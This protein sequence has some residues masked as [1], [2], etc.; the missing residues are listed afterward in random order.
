[1]TDEVKNQEQEQNKGLQTD[2]K[3]KGS[4]AASTKEESSKVM[5][6]ELT[7]EQY[8]AILDRMEEQDKVIEKLT[9]SSKK[10]KSESVQDIDELAREG[11]EKREKEQVEVDWDSMSNKE[12]VAT[13]FQLTEEHVVKPL[14][15]ELQT[16]KVMNEIDKAAAKYDDF[17][18]LQ[19]RIKGIAIE[20]PTLS[21]EKAYKMA[22]LEAEEETGARRKSKDREGN[23]ED[24]PSAKRG[25]GVHLLIPSRPTLGERPG[26]SG[27]TIR[28]GPARTTREAAERAWD[29]VVGKGGGGA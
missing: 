16:L 29:A 18:E 22:K 13:I 10:G 3:E 24:E 1:M 14:N 5:K 25:K 9:N 19:D 26:I 8:N 4:L 7:A 2:G 21:I 11:R 23:E 15:I 20:N 17:Y 12:L 28:Q 27:G 6:V